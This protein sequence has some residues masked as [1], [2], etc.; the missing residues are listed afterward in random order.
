MKLCED[1][2]L[3]FAMHHYDN[4]QCHTVQEF[5]ED[6]KRF[7]Y[8]RKLLNRYKRDGELKERLILNHII[9]LYNLFGDA[10][11]D[12]LFFKIE[13]EYWPALI[14]FLV[15]LNRIPEEKMSNVA[16]DENIVKV[17]RKI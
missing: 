8:L 16:L 11:T 2:F 4:Q 15:Y 5:E 9:V 3:L 1:N 14:T 10:L 13:E 7:L 12:M 17:L 6:L